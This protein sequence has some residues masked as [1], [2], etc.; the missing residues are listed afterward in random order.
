MDHNT[1]I[2][3]LEADIARLEA[4]AA[5]SLTSAV[6]ACPGWDLARLIG[7]VGRVERMV[8]AVVPT[9][10]MEPADPKSMES[11]PPD[12]DDLRAYFR[13]G[14]TRLVTELRAKSPDAPAWNFMGTSLNVGFW[15]RRQAHEHAIHRWDAESAIG[16]STPIDAALAVDGIDEYFE[17]VNS[18][19]LPKR[20]DF[21]LGGTAHLHATDIEGEWMLTPRA[22]GI[23][24][25][26]GHGKG[27]AAIRASASDLLLGLWGR[28]DLTEPDRFEL[29]GATAIVQ[30]LASV[31]GS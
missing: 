28:L 15:S 18:R 26:H 21:A 4:I 3:Y 25:A 13:S 29:F 20:P 16:P 8:L 11:P 5:G 7:H 22:G 19:V 10:A 24:M 14:A 1:F 6:P 31:G 23:D 17:I 9:G 12:H 27:D 30:A 2:N